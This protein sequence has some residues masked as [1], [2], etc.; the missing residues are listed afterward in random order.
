MRE[1]V[2][3]L[4]ALVASAACGCNREPTQ[5]APSAPV[6]E[7]PQATHDFGRPQQGRRLEHDFTLHNRGDRA[8]SVL[9]VEKSYSCTGRAATSSVPPGGSTTIHV[10]CDTE[11][12][13]GKMSDDVLVRTTDPVREKLKLT[14]LADV[15]PRLAFAAPDVRFE[16]AFGEQASKEVRL[17][18]ARARQAELRFGPQ[19]VGAPEV[20]LLPATETLPAGVR[21]STKGA[22]VGRR[23]G[24][25][26][27]R[28]G[29]DEPNELSLVYSLTIE[30]NVS[31]EPTNP[32]FNLREPP[33]RER[34]V[35]V[36]SKRKDFVLHAADIVE[37]PFRA[38]LTHD[39]ANQRYVV[40]VRFV[41]ESLPLNERG[42]V[43]KLLLVSNDP[44][45]PRK[46]VPLF[47]LGVRHEG[48]R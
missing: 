38:E 16:L 48:P 32:Y 47:A 41:D 37:G 35:T 29:L 19:E 46:E 44:A 42:A 17:T 10:E 7:C 3:A 13:S 25:L 15:E 18:G 34:A 39:E 31:V 2:T 9:G 22:P 30:G 5:T 27:F 12:F 1:V 24:Q 8:L 23:V 33:P 11:H 28:T 21:V 14:V 36:K 45:E 43:G 20:D 4:T 26:R 40:Q 6:V